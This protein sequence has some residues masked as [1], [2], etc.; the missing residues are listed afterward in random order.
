MSNLILKQKVQYQ[1]R[2]KAQPDET[3]VETTKPP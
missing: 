3:H 2:P 1:I